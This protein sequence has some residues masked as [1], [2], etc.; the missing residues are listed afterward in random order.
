MG[1]HDDLPDY[2][3][4]QIIAQMIP[5]E[6]TE[7][8]SEDNGPEVDPAAKTESFP[9]MDTS[10]LT[11]M[12]VCRRWRE[13]AVETSTF[14]HYIDI[15][16]NPEWTKLALA[17]SSSCAIDVSMVMDD[18]PHFD[19]MEL[20]IPHAGRIRRLRIGHVDEEHVPAIVKL[21]GM[22]LPALEDFCLIRGPWHTAPA[23]ESMVD[24]VAFTA[25]N[26]P[27][28]RFFCLRTIPI[29]T[30]PILYRSLRTLS[31]DSCNF[32]GVSFDTFFG[33][34]ARS[35]DLEEISLALCLSPDG[36][37]VPGLPSPTIN[38][39]FLPKLS[40]VVLIQ[41]TPSD[42]AGFLA[43]IQLPPNCHLSIDAYR[44]NGDEPVQ[45]L[46]SVLPPNYTTTLPVLQ[47]VSEVKL[48]TPSGSN[49]FEA[50]A[51]DHDRSRGSLFVCQRDLWRSWDEG[52][53]GGLSDLPQAF[54]SAPLTRLTLKCDGGPEKVR[55]SYTQLE[56][57][58]RTFPT[59]EYISASGFDMEVSVLARFDDAAGMMCPRLKHL[60]TNDC[61]TLGGYY[62][63]MKRLV[64]CVRIRADRG[65]R[66]SR[67]DVSMRCAYGNHV[68]MGEEY[69]LRLEPFVD[70]VSLKS[71]FVYDW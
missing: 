10:W 51:R 41:H 59:L 32:G 4:V 17:R 18:C 53:S 34:L 58:F 56:L 21:L 69:R 49:I 40:K 55:A 46:L 45:S 39:I 28:L 22:E 5:Y 13:I 9:L 60:E 71:F 36:L 68:A 63:A 50:V 43:R 37:L 27:R 64:D 19:A 24:R 2:L 52:L 14:W 42:T 35:V 44:G 29:P 30:D 26:L 65:Y 12:L 1:V 33:L 11:I 6:A 8:A 70:T 57:L 16:R 38:P 15:G 66:L 3:L 61:S 25:Q 54:S 7:A 31:L 62:G 23:L 20:L 67:L 48:H 47:H